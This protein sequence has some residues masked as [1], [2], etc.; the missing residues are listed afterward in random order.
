MTCLLQWCKT[1]GWGFPRPSGKQHL[2]FRRHMAS[3]PA[4]VGEDP[5]EQGM[6]AHSN[7]LAGESHG[8]RSLVSYSL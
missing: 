8:Q 7:I 6:V 2:Q 5:L 3:I 1:T 4:W